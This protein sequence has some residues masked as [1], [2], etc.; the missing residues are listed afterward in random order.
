[1]CIRHSYS[2]LEEKGGEE[3]M[4][5]WTIL[6]L[7]SVIVAPYHSDDT[8]WTTGYGSIAKAPVNIYMYTCLRLS[9]PR[10]HWEAA[11]GE[12]QECQCQHTF[13]QKLEALKIRLMNY[14]YRGWGSCLRHSTVHPEE[15]IIIRVF[16]LHSTKGAACAYRRNTTPFAL[17][18]DTTQVHLYACHA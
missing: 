13:P 16:P 18:G 6:S 15:L 3:R 11:V 9:R 12:E 4:R 8:G 10:E 14:Q 17:G 1:M 5:H 7:P 2:L